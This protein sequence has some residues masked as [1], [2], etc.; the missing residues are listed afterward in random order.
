MLWKKLKQLLSIDNK[1]QVTDLEEARKELAE[2]TLV[3]INQ[4]LSYYYEYHVISPKECIFDINCLMM[5]YLNKY[6]KIINN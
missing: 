6:N 3:K 4:Q 2:Q 5:A 1:Y